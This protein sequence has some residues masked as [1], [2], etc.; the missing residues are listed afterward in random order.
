MPYWKNDSK[1][2]RSR[3]PR[4]SC[5]GQTKLLLVGEATNEATIVT[6]KPV[7]FALSRELISHTIE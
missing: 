4:L 5:S 1:G 3:I 2:Q 7:T 6:R